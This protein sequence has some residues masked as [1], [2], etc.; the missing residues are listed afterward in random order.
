[1]Y[2]HC[3]PIGGLT[4]LEPRRPQNFDKPPL[5]YMA[6]S[7]PMALMYGVRNFEYTYGYT[8]SG[9]IY[10]EEYFPDA[11][12]QLYAGKS[13]YLYEC[14]PQTTE[15]TKIPNEVVSSLPVEILRETYI[16]DVL[17]AL[18]EQ[19]RLGAL[20]ICRHEQLSPQMREWIFHAELEEIR[21]RGLLQTPGP[22]ADY[23]K[24]RYPE[25]WAA[26]CTEKSKSPED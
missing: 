5:V 24:L 22:M 14:A 11:L 7:L 2:Y 25:V 15:V 23:I 16:P 1:M 3:S 18:L 10:Y 12:Q 17:Q 13:A 26:A 6:T 21:K 19:E 20:M 8:K 4:R 9:Q